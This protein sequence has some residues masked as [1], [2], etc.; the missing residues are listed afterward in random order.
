MRHLALL[1]G[2]IVSPHASE[3][4]N[5]ACKLG[6]SRLDI[7]ELATGKYHINSNGVNTLTAGILVNCGYNR[8][9]SDNIVTCNNNIIAAHHR[10]FDLWHNPPAHTFGPQVN[11]ILLK[12]FKLFPTLESMGM[13]DVLNFYDWF[14]ELST[15]HLLA[16]MP[17]DV[18]IL[19]HG[20]EGLCILGLGV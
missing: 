20:L 15:S 6:T 17:F 10:I 2:P 13:D 16:H 5:K 19:K 9:T 14:Q 12:S 1:G 8:I 4:E 3:W 7:L 11:Q 18:I